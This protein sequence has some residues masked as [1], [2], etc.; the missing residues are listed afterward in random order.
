VDFSTLGEAEPYIW[1]LVDF[2]LNYHPEVITSIYS[3]SPS[4]NQT[5]P[6]YVSGDGP[7][8]YLNLGDFTSVYSFR[9]GWEDCPSGCLFEHFWQFTVDD[10]Y[11]YEQSHY[12][13]DILLL[14]LSAVSTFGLAPFTTQLL[15]LSLIGMTGPVS[16]AWDLDND[17]LADSAEQHPEWIFTDPGWHSVTLQI[18]VGDFS[19]SMTTAD[20]IFAGIPGDITLDLVVDILDIVQVVEIVLGNTSVGEIQILCAD[21]NSDEIIDILDVILLVDMI[22]SV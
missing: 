6:N 8:V 13:D 19:D 14:S 4:V 15:D 21:L 10:T 7:D 17:G 22:L 16:W 3:S 12:G 5:S 1:I 11:I 2:E 20:L 9:I 18:Q